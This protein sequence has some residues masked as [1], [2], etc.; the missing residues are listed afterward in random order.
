MSFAIE[1]HNL[2]YAYAR[3][4]KSVNNLSLQ[5][6]AG[7]I[8]GFLGPNGAG[9]TTTIRLLT[10]MLLLDTDNVFIQGLSLKK[11]SP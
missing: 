9:K 2:N 8:Y 7:S 10:G 5:V 3:G 11:K 6:P 1:T 4:R